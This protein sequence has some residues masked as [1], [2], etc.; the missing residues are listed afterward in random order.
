MREFGFPRLRDTPDSVSTEKPFKWKKTNF[1]T[2]LPK[3][4][5][6][7]RYLV[8]KTQNQKEKY[9]MHVAVLTQEYNPRY[10]VPEEL[11]RLKG[12]AQ[13]L[14]D[15]DVNP[16]PEYERM[17]CCH[18]IEKNENSTLGEEFSGVSSEEEAV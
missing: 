9:F 8:A 12:K 11:R 15:E 4:T 1:V 7:A 16:A 3:H 13:K 5:P 18:I 6:S 14:F 2:D 10:K 17:L